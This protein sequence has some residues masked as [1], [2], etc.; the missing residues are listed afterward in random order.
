MYGQHTW[1]VFNMSGKRTATK[2]TVRDT[3][4]L[5]IKMETLDDYAIVFWSGEDGHK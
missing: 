4:I 5:F 2:R 3:P 1:M